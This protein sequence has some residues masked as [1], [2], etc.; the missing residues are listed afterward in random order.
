MTPE[1]N[2]EYESLLDKRDGGTMSNKEYKRYLILLDKAFL[3]G[4]P[5][6]LNTWLSPLSE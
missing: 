5:K 6:I 1:E 3:Q 2:K 4:I